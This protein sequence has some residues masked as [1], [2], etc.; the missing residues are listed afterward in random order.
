MRLPSLAVLAALSLACAGSAIAKT[1]D[2]KRSFDPASSR[3]HLAGPTTK[4]MVL[5]TSHLDNAPKGF[6]PAW[7]APVMCRLQAYAPDAIMIE[8]MSGEQL[9]QIDAFKAVRGNAGKWGGATL[10]IAKDA[11]ASL[12]INPAEALAQADVLAAK[13]GLS[14]SERRKLAGLFLAAA[15]PF[16]AATQWLQLAPADRVAGDGVTEKMKKMIEF[17]GAGRGEMS[18]M[19]VALAVQLGRPRVYSVGDHLSDMALPDDDAFGTALKANPA[20]IAGLNKTTPELALYSSKALAIDAPDR[21]MPFFR[22]LNSPTFGRLDAQAQWLSLQQTPSM[23][24]VGRQRVAAW[25]A[26]NLHMATGVREVTAPTPG[27]K[28]LLIVGAAHKAFIEAYLRS[29]TD[30][31]I[32]SVPAM[33]DA[34]PAGC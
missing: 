13:S 5:G 24:A 14:T 12:G 19:A 4:V 16:S 25:E 8:A 28:A 26:Q 11:Q 1:D 3:A 27:G 17:I 7:L 9:T 32:V 22:T 10:D 21:V 30:I 23:G 2:G 31:E 15:E 6:D 18:S 33:L 29:M 34:T 20:I